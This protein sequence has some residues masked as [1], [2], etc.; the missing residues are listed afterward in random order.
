MKF[1]GRMFREFF[2]TI[3]NQSFELGRALWALGCFSMIAYQAVAIFA[4][5]QAFNPMEFGTGFGGLLV[6]GG[7]GVAA[8]DKIAASVKG[9]ADKP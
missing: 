2:T 8:K 9:P 5:S 1:L 3:D 7:F 4:K 6:A